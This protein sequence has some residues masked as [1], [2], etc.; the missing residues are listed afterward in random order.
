MTQDAFNFDAA[1]AARDAGLDRA[2]NPMFRRQLLESAR[3]HA[4]ELG[5]SII[6][7]TMDDVYRRM[8]NY[9]EN[10]ELLGNASGAVFL[11]SEWQWMG[12]RLSERTERH[13]GRNS[14]WR[15]KSA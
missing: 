2:C 10:P 11:K 6:D 4:R 7:V 14:I 8:M 1:V 3:K 9:G 12:T 15:L 13:C 5:A